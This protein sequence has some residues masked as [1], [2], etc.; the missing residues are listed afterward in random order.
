MWLVATTLDSIVLDVLI[1]GQEL[2]WAQKEASWKESRENRDK[3]KS[4]TLV[5]PVFLHG[6]EWGE[7]G[8]RPA[9]QGS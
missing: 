5:A 3:E 8:K 6:H 7:Q 2:T 9:S 1:F 4:A